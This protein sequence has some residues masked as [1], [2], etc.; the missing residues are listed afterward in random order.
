MPW[1]NARGPSKRS[2]V[3]WGLLWLIPAALAFSSPA[4]AHGLPTGVEAVSVGAESVLAS[5]YTLLP[6]VAAGLLIGQHPFNRLPW[7]WAALA[8]GLSLGC[9]AA[10]LVTLRLVPAPVFTLLVW[11]L[12]GVMGLAAAAALL[13]AA[14]PRLPLGVSIGLIA[15]LGMLTGVL[16]SDDHADAE[17][18]GLVAM[19]CGYGVAGQMIPAGLGCFAAALR[20]AWPSSVWVGIGLRIVAA[21]TAAIALLIL[22]VDATAPAWSEEPQPT[23]AMTASEP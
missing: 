7:T 22:T 23:E 21:W 19:L 18:G 9:I 15:V 1:R 3:G 4:A 2:L 16:A 13:A 5:P 6:A 20:Q 17:T 10:I 11:S 8:G 12:F 14:L